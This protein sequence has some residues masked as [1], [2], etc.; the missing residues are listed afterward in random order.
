MS[1][2]DSVQ[3]S[4]N[5]VEGTQAE[6]ELVI[7]RSELSEYNPTSNKFV[8]INLPVADKSWIDWSDSVLSL[9]FTNRS[10]DDTSASTS[11]SA[12]KTE[13]QNLIKSITILNS[14]GE[15][16]EYINNYNLIAN[17]MNDYTMSTSH[18][19]SVENILAGGS[20]DGNPDSAF[21]VAG[22]NA[23]SEADGS[24]LIM[25]DKLMCGFCSGQ[26]LLP[27][28]YLVGQAPAIVLELETPTTAL[29]INTT[30]NNNAAYKISDVQIRAKQ[31]RFNSAFNEAFERTLAEAGSVGINY[32][33]ESFLHNQ[34]SI[35]TGTTG[36]FNVP[37]STNPRS[38]KYILAMGRLETDVQNQAK[39]SLGVRSSMAITQYSWEIAGKMYP[40]QP[41]ELSDTN[42]SQ[43]YAN[44]LDCLGQIGALNHSNLISRASTNTLFYNNT[45]ST[46][47]KF[48]A[49]L[50]L[51]DFNS[52]TNP[53]IYSGANLSTVGQMTWRPQIGTAL[54]A[55]YRIDLFTSIDM[56]IH[57]TA[58]GRC[59]SVK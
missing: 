16:V 7:F 17:L 32:I 13:L 8:R 45:Q 19:A 58:D 25:T 37:F 28:G 30:A 43:G 48:V 29:K 35:P 1:T 6:S 55:A 3:F 34:S 59:Y 46:G 33:T 31:I 57:F 54:S 52:A 21:E 26:Y 41:I 20:A 9:K 4:S 40:T 44:V 18:K 2:P 15:Q 24:S 42:Y 36:Q 51:E 10:F 14:Q 50:V 38:A 27:L 22:A 56:S 53:S 39:Y 12:V 47:Q 11:E 5:P 49:G 23:T